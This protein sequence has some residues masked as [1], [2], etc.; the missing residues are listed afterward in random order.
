MVHGGT[1]GFH[2]GGKPVAVPAEAKVHASSG[3]TDEAAEPV[4]D[5]AIDDDGGGHAQQH[6]AVE[7]CARMRGGEVADEL[8]EGMTK[9][10][11]CVVYEEH[12][13][14]KPALAG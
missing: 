7:P 11:H 9:V 4:A 12:N 13:R 14:K 1:E 2:V 6:K 3:M 5:A 10:S 8:E